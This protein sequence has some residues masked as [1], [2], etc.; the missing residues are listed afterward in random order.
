MKKE[1]RQKSATTKRF[2]LSLLF[3]V[4]V[5]CILLAAIGL[6]I[7]IIYILTLAGM[8]EGVEEE[9]SVKT[10][11]LYMLISSAVLGAAISLLLAKFPL[12]PVNQL[13]DQM[14]RLA[15]GDF[16]TRLNF[17]VLAD[18]PVFIELAGSFNKLAEELE[19]TEI[20]RSDF[21]NNFSHEFKT[22][23]VSIAGLA[24]LL[25]RGKLDEEQRAQYLTAIEEESRRL[26]S[27]ATNVLM[28]TKVENQSILT[29][30]SVFNL[31]E[32]LRSCLLLLENKWTAK[33]IDLQLSMDEYTVR[34]NEELLREVWINLIDNAIKFSPRGG[35]VSIEIGQQGDSLTVSICNDGEEIG[36]AEQKKI[37]SKFYQ[38]DASHSHEG[39][40]IGLAIV[41]RIVELHRGERAVKCEAGRVTFSVTLPIK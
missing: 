6:S 3:A 7:T 40:G 15:A 21:I 10:V 26:A 31:S 34:A 17:G 1:K 12:R 25:N 38:A 24:R 16:K 23:I 11:L 35:R 18:H 30:L 33:E 32:Q 36:E 9:L 8:S 37:W 5:F 28:L 22:P 27:M 4:V 14:N 20:L 19:N 41:K 13:I 39:N 29:D 2:S